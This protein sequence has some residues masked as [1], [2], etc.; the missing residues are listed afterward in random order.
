MTTV[1]EEELCHRLD[2]IT[3]GPWSGGV[4]EARRKLAPLEKLGVS[5]TGSR[6][7]A[8]DKIQFSTSNKQKS[9][10]LATILRS[11]FKDKN[12]ITSLTEMETRDALDQA[13]TLPQLYELAVQTGYLP[14]ERVRQPA[15]KILTDLLWSPAARGFVAAYDYIAVPMLAARVG[16]SGLDVVQP[17]EPNENAALRFAGFLAH[18]RAFEADE[19]IETW[20]RFL[21]DYVQEPN[22]Q[23]KVWRYLRGQLKTA[24][25][26]TAEIL[27]G[28]QRFVTSMA[29]AFHVLDDDELG[30]FGLIHAYWLQK[31]FGYKM[32]DIG[33]VKDIDLWGPTDSWARTVMT[34]PHLVAAG[35][36]SKISKVFRQQ[37]RENVRLLDRTFDA[38]RILAKSTRQSTNV[39]VQLRAPQGPSSSSP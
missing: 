19:Q 35:I 28:C 22:E 31:F 11:H 7:I 34:S 18:L 15:R 32:E 36:N 12:G 27:T 10:R 5:V 26:R 30:R 23:D 20:T 33:Y 4:V 21:D 24:P 13:L 14:A 37:F 9:G 38:V 3:R 1:S 6:Q 39:P 2:A 16:V 17:P 25:E 8:L 29:S